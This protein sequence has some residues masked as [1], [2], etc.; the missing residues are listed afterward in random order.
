MRRGRGLR[1]GRG[2]DRDAWAEMIPSIATDSSVS[3]GADKDPA[4]ARKGHGWGEGGC[5][6]KVGSRRQGPRP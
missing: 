3:A 5:S 6:T 2:V 4:R 1:D